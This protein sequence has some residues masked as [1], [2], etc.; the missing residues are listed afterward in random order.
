MTYLVTGGAGFI[1]SHIAE[2]LLRQGKR[3]RVLDNLTTGLRA[4]LDHLKSLRGDLD[5]VEADLNDLDAS[6][7]ACDGIDV[8]F[9][10]AALPSVGRSVEFPISTNVA[11]VSG[12]LTFLCSARAAAIRRVVYSASSSAY[13]DVPS[14][15][16]ARDRATPKR[17]DMLPRP[18]SPYAVSKLAGEYYMRA[19]HQ[20]YG[21]ETVCLRYFN[22]FGPR[23]SPL[24]P[25]GA[26]IP[27]FGSAMLRN[28]SPTVFGDGRQS[29]DFTYVDNAVEANL[30]AASA[31]A[32]RVS[33]EVFNVACG[34]SA[35]LLQVIEIINRALGK[36]LKP[37]FAAPRAGD[38]RHSKADI[39]K[40]ERLLEYRVEVPLAEGVE[41]TIE[42]LRDQM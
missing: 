21:M 12:T 35:T 5:V 3:V 1:G 25:Y 11:N 27:K 14:A 15:P 39:S 9:H 41:R 22:I 4:N 13:G 8:A 32:K 20:V 33:G 37:R 16:G 42:W 38:V 2:K 6:R 24:S 26:A 36:R 10:L 34:D 30:L 28:E 31:P 18:L 40:A 23:Q 29:R 7:R 19:F 17:E